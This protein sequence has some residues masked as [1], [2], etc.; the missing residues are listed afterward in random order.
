MARNSNLR[1]TN[2]ITFGYFRKSRRMGKGEQKEVD[3]QGRNR[4]ETGKAGSEIVAL[5]R[6]FPAA[7]P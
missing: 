4:T 3:E 6:I 7:I 2:L 5:V 1:Q